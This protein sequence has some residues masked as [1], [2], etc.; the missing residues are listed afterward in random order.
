MSLVDDLP[1]TSEQI[2]NIGDDIV[3]IV[4]EGD[5]SRVFRKAI[6]DLEQD[7]R[8]FFASEATPDGVPWKPLAPST[9]QRKGHSRILIDTTKMHRS[10][11]SGGMSSDGE[12][13]R[14]II[15]EGS[16]KGFSFGTSIPYAHYHQD[17]TGRIPQREFLGFTEERLEQIENDVLDRVI[18]LI[19]GSE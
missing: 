7:V 15:E 11:T 16:N 5:F 10:L 3:D 17:G 9:V 19:T 4:R 18:D 14:E 13:V 1:Y 2:T 8:G 6:Y 12:S